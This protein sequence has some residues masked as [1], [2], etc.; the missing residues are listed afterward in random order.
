MPYKLASLLLSSEQ[1][2]SSIAKIAWAEAEPGQPENETH[3]SR[4]GKIFSLVEVYASN[5]KALL[6][7]DFFSERPK[8]NYYQQPGIDQQERLSLDD[9]E[10]F[11]T[12]AIQQTN[13]ELKDF[14][15]D[16]KID[17]AKP[18][19]NATV[20]LLTDKGLFLASIGRNQAWTLSPEMIVGKQIIK[21]IVPEDG[22]KAS[23][24]FQ[25]I[26]T[27]KLNKNSYLLIS[28]EALAEYIEPSTALNLLANKS[29]LIGVEKM[30][31]FLQQTNRRVDFLGLV[32]KHCSLS[33]QDSDSCAEMPMNIA[34]NGGQ[35]STVPTK[36][37]G[38]NL[39]LTE[40]RTE[41]I[42][43]P[44][45]L[46]KFKQFL[47]KIVIWG[48]ELSQK[49]IKKNWRQFFQE[50]YE[51]VRDGYHETKEKISAWSIWPKIGKYSRSAK[52]IIKASWYKVEPRFK[53]I[54]NR[55]L[56]Y[57]YK[58]APQRCR[59]VEKYWLPVGRK[60]EPL[61]KTFKKFENKKIWQPANTWQKMSK[62]SR[63]LLV[64]VVACL[65]M[66]TAGLLW[67]KH[68]QQVANIA[69]QQNDKIALVDQKHNQIEANLLYNN[70]DSAN[71][72]LT[73]VENLIQEYQASQVEMAEEIKSRWQKAIIRQEELLGR[74]R[75]IYTL[76]D[77]QK[78]SGQTSQ[79]TSTSAVALRL[80]GQLLAWSDSQT[81]QVN[82]QNSRQEWQTISWP[83]GWTKIVAVA[84]DGQ[85]WYFVNDNSQLAELN[86]DG[87]WKD[88]ELDKK[89]DQIKAVAFY[90]GRLYLI[91]QDNQIY[92]YQKQNNKFVGG[93]KS[94][95]NE[96]LPAGEI[97]GLAID[98]Q[99]YVFYQDGRLFKFNNGRQQKIEV[100]TVEPKIT[101]W[102]NCQIL[103]DS[104]DFYCLES[105]SQ[106][107]LHYGKDGAI[108]AQ[109]KLVKNALAVAI[110]KTAQAIYL[111]TDQALE[112]FA[113]PTEQKIQSVDSL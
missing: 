7:L 95:N 66:L 97:V 113:L 46:V 8:L 61:L 104:E 101:G 28:N 56:A 100:K 94:W 18:E 81:K 77:G 50:Y 98:G 51:D 14:L 13:N 89:V 24:F 1:K 22:E 20:G 64:L 84:S 82:Y 71:Q 73:E 15:A 35:A 6:L 91:A 92:R 25:E 75:H 11:F 16:N 67:Q 90:G 32:I 109:Y 37:T 86:R 74:V 72:S 96:K 33:E 27:G 12:A 93:Q 103:T 106:R 83:Q 31:H 85:S 44:S 60:A 110:S 80:N 26:F 69:K 53:N 40:E 29:P 108:I 111:L 57:W 9:L 23:R 78:M 55:F 76:K 49:I 43:N 47:T 30:R 41:K 45:G 5:A 59:L 65:I 34:I 54:S 10:K 38:N 105:G 39:R 63:L 3:F 19:V 68:A 4:V 21:M 17:Y 52:T 2:S 36:L 58:T 107:I 42:L 62:R 88:W 102:A 48:K 99:A 87:Q 112:R 79:P 70:L